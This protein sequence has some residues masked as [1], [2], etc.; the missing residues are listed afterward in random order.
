MA[1]QP[2]KYKEEYNEQARKLCLLGHT[3]AELIKFFDVCESTLNNWK[4]EYPE[5]LASIKIGKDDFDSSTV[6]KSLRHRAL[7]YEHPE[8]KV[9]LSNGEIITHDT[10]KHYPPDTAAAIFWLKNRQPGRWRDKQIIEQTNLN[11][12]LTAEEREDKI[13]ELE[14]RMKK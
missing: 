14:S 10:I 3:D 4:N 12:E 9:F 11:V 8:E 7:G 13:K 1:G 6:E 5:F 2:T